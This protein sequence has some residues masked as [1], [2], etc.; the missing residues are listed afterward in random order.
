MPFVA[1]FFVHQIS[2]ARTV[3]VK[4]AG[5]SSNDESPQIK[6]LLSKTALRAVLYVK[7]N[8]KHVSLVL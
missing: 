4:T 2:E 8:V 1:E 6:L 7:R 3:A 5:G